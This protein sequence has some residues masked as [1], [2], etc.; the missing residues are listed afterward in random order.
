[1]M[2]YITFSVSLFCVTVVTVVTA[3]GRRQKA[4]SAKAEGAAIKIP[5]PL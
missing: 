1:M 5:A 4:E 2:C 3:E